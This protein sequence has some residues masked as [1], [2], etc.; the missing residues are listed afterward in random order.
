MKTTKIASIILEKIQSPG[1]TLKEVAELIQM[2]KHLTSR[3]L[4]LVNTSYSSS[5]EAISDVNKALH[6]IGTSTLIQVVLTA[7]VL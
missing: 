4:N 3:I 1:A 7:R 5:Q 2:D 6:Y